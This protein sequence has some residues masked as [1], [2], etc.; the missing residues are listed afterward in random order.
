[1]HVQHIYSIDLY[2]NIVYR[3]IRR[4]IVSTTYSTVYITIPGIL[5]MYILQI[6]LYK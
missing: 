2:T 6:S 3:Y 5:I 4:Y 1:M